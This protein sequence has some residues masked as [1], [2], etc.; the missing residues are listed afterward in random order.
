MTMQFISEDERK[1][2]GFD[3]YGVRDERAG[4]SLRHPCPVYDTAPTAQ[5]ALQMVQD[6]LFDGIEGDVTLCRV[7][8]ARDSR[9]TFIGY[10]SDMIHSVTFSVQG[11]I[12]NLLFGGEE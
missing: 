9:G 12:N 1:E 7:R 4:L 10:E 3:P 8:Y 11:D 6:L 5:A 2:R